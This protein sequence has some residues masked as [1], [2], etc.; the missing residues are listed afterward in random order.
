MKIVIFDLDETLGYFVKFGIFWDCLNKYFFHHKIEYSLNQSDFNEILDLYPE[1]LRPNIVAILNYLKHKKNNNCCNKIMIYT[2]NQGSKIWTDYLMSYF[3]KKIKYD[4]FDKIIS[5]FKINGNVVEICRTTH[6]KTYH[7]LI[8][9]TKI[10]LHAKICFLDDTY[11]PEMSHD[12]VYYINIKPY[13]HDLSFEEMIERFLH[14]SFGLKWIDPSHEEI[15]INEM[16][17]YLHSYLYTYIKKTE[18]ENE[19]D[20]IVSKQ[21]MIHL[22]HFFNQTK[23][24]NRSRH[25]KYTHKHNKT[26][27]NNS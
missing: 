3:Q 2:N 11:F 10:P 13:V 25:K 26:K 24:A 18:E 6:D 4:L 19:I 12:N 22:Q 7:D 8:K 5:A 14:S 1:F 27:R 20:K 17:N 23:H 9:C 15:F 21:I 16:M